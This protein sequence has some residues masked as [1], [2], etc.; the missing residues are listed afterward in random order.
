MA[1]VPRSAKVVVGQPARTAKAD[2]PEALLDASLTPH[3]FH[4]L[5]ACQWP[6]ARKATIDHV[7]VGPTGVWVVH[8][9]RV[10][11]AADLKDADIKSAREQASAVQKATGCR[12]PHV[13]LAIVGGQVAGGAE[14][15]D[16]VVIVAAK[17]TSDV[18]RHAM[19]V[20]RPEGVERLATKARQALEPKRAAPR[21]AVPDFIP[22][23]VVDGKPTPNGARPKRRRRAWRVAL[24]VVLLA[25]LAALVPTA[26]DA[27]SDDAAPSA[28]TTE[29][30]I[31]VTF[32]CRSPG[33][34]WS[35]V[36]VWPGLR[37]VRS[38]SWATAPEGPWVALPAAYGVAAVRDGVA[39]SEAS[40]VRIERAT[41]D[42][43]IVESMAT[44][45]APD[46]PC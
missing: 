5:H 13:V 3:G 24:A 21:G 7:V 26:L 8:D 22:D 46:Q 25:A 44:V 36:I 37:N 14:E 33:A 23:W 39:P 31:H 11:D 18:V 6:G 30:D 10:T 12:P 41:D 4:C 40:F 32:E 43:E 9:V 28:A 38:V 1:D 42:S 29:P 17:R 34:G 45:A 20:L 19:T 16:G 15:R 27:L 2:T 35:Q